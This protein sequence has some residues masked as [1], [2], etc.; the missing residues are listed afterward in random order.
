MEE[1]QL[2]TATNTEQNV[3]APQPVADQAP[4]LEAARPQPATCAS[5]KGGCG[6]KTSIGGQ[7][8]IEGVMMRGPK[9]TAL[10]V[11]LPNGEIDTELMPTRNLKEKCPIFG[12][13]LVRGV[14]NML[15]SLIFGTKCLYISA[16]KSGMEDLDEPQSKFEK[17]LDKVLGDKLFG[18]IMGI[19]TA[20]GLV[21][22]V[23]LFLFL[24]MWLASLSESG[25]VALGW[26]GEGGIGLWKNL[27]EGVIK[28]LIFVLYMWASSHLK[29]MRRVFEYHGAEHKSI[30]CYEAG[31]ELTPENAR[32]FK[33]FHPRCGTSFIF[34]VLIISI[35]VSCV[36]TWENTLIRMLLKIAV[37]PLIVGI[38]Y[39]CIKLAGRYDNWFTRLLSAPGQWMQ[40][41]T[42]KEPDDSMLEV[43]IASL[44]AVIP[45]NEEEAK[46]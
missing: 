9:K 12:W 40:R 46:W 35:L 25:I 24:P 5:Q 36:I 17:W 22:S 45:E 28:I 33:R 1:N 7:A 6:F 39:E 14:V 44:K 15:D 43:A 27:I 8:L 13:P 34:L 26:A 41:I 37:L 10:S 4:T 21:L 20:L 32:R 3:S 18:I 31:E 23:A 2:Q 38:G 19:G 42:T 16:E 30:A 11:R 29:E